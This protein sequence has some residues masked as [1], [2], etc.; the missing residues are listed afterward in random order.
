MHRQISRYGAWFLLGFALLYYGQ[1][2][3]SGLYP[4]AEG[5]VEGMLAL[6]LLEGQR[7][8]VDT[9]MGYNLFWFYPIVALFKLFGPSYTALRI[10][11]FILCTLTG[12]MTFRLVR[13]ATGNAVAALLGGLLV[14]MIPGQMFRNYMAF[15][16]VLNMSVFVPA[17]LL[18]LRSPSVRLLWMACCGVTL[19]IAWLIRVDVGFFLSCVWIGLVISFP[20]G[21][22][23][24]LERAKIASLGGLLALFCFIALHIP[25]YLDAS[26]R[27]FASEFAGQYQQWP[28]MIGSQG[29]KVIDTIS[30]STTAIFHQ[31]ASKVLP[32]VVLPTPVSSPSS[33]AGR[34]A[35]AFHQA[36]QGEIKSKLSHASLARRSIYA[37]SVRDKMLAINIY[38]P[39]VIAILL[40][41]AS[42]SV[43]MI[44]LG[45]R[46]SL[47]RDRSLILLTSLGCSLAL[48]PQYFFW[49]PD[50]VHLS[51]FMVPMTMTTVVAI[52]YGIFAWRS[53][54]RLGRIG[55]G[56]GLALSVLMLILYY[57]NAFQSQSSGGI[58]AGLNKRVE[59]HAANGVDVRLT[60]DEFRD[61]TAIYRII[62]AASSHG[63]YLICYPYNPE[64]NFMTDR[65]SYEYNFYIDNVMISP[66]RFYREETEKMAHFH[67]AAFVITDWEINN[68]EE[69]RFSNWAAKTYAFIQENYK[70]AY[71]R[72][73]LEA[74][75]RPD[76]VGKIPADLR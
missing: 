23:D 38:L 58:A 61:A 72:G 63:D 19:A 13:L 41:V 45:R 5:G 44:A 54:S 68:T 22:R 48:F 24:F 27:G 66:E 14:I 71:K 25:V 75:I 62:T 74:F 7:P 56:S 50:M 65:P 70:L 18:P 8:I 36:L 37:G 29:K 1:Y 67:P 55:L 69:S 53:S 30:K 9:F 28:S 47:L 26:K 64:I 17:F 21:H 35:V 46:D 40:G 12:M 39:V 3:R 51:E 11:F 15:M 43:W 59:F 32:A 31:P 57:I 52:T 20:I 34:E 49:R 6:R 16:V 2:Y 60:P 4:A 42:L 73:N 33:S 10:F 76:L